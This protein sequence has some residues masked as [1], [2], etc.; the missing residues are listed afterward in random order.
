MDRLSYSHHHHHHHHHQQQQQQQQQQHQQQQQQQT[1]TET[2]KARAHIYSLPTFASGQVATL[3]LTS[4][5]TTLVDFT[6]A[7]THGSDAYLVP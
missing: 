6:S 4:V 5:S 1:S 7:F 2:Q 3:D